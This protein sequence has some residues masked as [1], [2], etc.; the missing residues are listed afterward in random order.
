M[1][2]MRLGAAGVL[3]IA[4]GAGLAASGDLRL[5]QAVRSQDVE[6]ARALVAEGIDVN[7]T[8]GD[9]S[10]ALHWAAHRNDLAI[11]DLLIEAGA[12]VRVVNDL[13][14]TPLQVACENRSGP[15]VERL[16]A[17]GAPANATLLN[18]ETTLMSCAR[19]GDARSVA[20]L[21]AHG[22]RVNEV[23]SGHQQTALMWAAAQGH[24][25]IVR[26]L[27]EAGA[28]VRARSRTYARTV[29][30]EQTQRA[31]REE[32]NYTVQRG[33]STPLLFAARNGDAASARLLL[34]AGAE[35]NDALSDGMSALTLAAHS[36]HSAVGI[37]LLEA[38]ANPNNIGIGYTALHAA[39]LRSRLDLVEAL[40]AFGAH[41][42]IRIARGTPL[43]RNTTDFNLPKTLVGAT[44][45]LLAAKFAEAE[46]MRALMAGGADLGLTMPDGTTALL[47][48]AGLGTRQ[49]SRRGISSLDVGGMPEPESQVLEAVRAA[50][51]LGAD[52]STGHPDG[53]TPL[54]EAAGNEHPTV[55]RFLAEQGADVNARNGR[56]L[57]PL[58]LLT[59][60]ARA[61][62]EASGDDGVA[63]E[64]AT[65]RLLREL[66]ATQP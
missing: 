16:L 58:A 28:A 21:L 26:L 66:G 20:A 45:Y 40:L 56:G 30:D 64:S 49:G 36:G 53:T 47:L 33:G 29:V 38:G 35:P 25:E 17:A 12:D 60:R 18:G 6:L 41:P 15:T 32:L 37:A 42:N 3:V 19:T 4:S 14:T 57:T 11:T 31:G 48:A 44:P 22:A 34:D 2:L 46:I 9:G 65:V 54:H 55:V 61:S 50:V 62:R 59:G 43:R 24:P 13:G 52:V 5:I 51:E 23:E 10:T 27:L 7:E 8:Q 39:V 1:N 63:A